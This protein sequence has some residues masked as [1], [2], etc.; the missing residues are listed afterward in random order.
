MRSRELRVAGLVLAGSLNIAGSAMKGQ[1]LN[2]DQLRSRLIASSLQAEILELPFEDPNTTPTM[3]PESGETT[4][5]AS[6]KNFDDVDDYNG[7][8]SS[9]Q[10]KVGTSISDA[11]GLTTTVSVALVDPSQLGD[12]GGGTP[13]SDVKRI[14][15][16]V[17]RGSVVLTRLVSV[18]TR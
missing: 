13:S 4:S 11:N 12:G 8:S 6:R 5:P 15:V 3:G 2:N 1:V 10:T 17:L 9:P 7:W 14:V 16:T 18:V